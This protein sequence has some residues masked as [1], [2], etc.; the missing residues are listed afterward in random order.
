MCS[1]N[2]KD[3]TAQSQ[4]VFEAPIGRLQTPLW[5]MHAFLAP[6]ESRVRFKDVG[7]PWLSQGC[8]DM[9]EQELC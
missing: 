7:T 6:C 8:Y 5:V 3:L 2:H 9:G 1:A 4:I